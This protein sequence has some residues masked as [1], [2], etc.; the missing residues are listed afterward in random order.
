MQDKYGFNPRKCNSAATFSGCVEREMSKIIIV[1]PTSNEVVNTFENT[2]NG[3][4]SSV[5][6]RLGFDTEVFLPNNCNRGET[7]NS[8]Y[9][10]YNYKV[11]YN[12]S[13]NRNEKYRIISK[14]IKFD[15]NNQYG[16]AMTKPMPTGC[17]HLN[18]D[19]SFKTFNILLE[20]VDLND[21]VGH[22]YLV[23]IE[24]DLEKR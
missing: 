17:I 10:D 3:G 12:L 13:N 8:T 4:F 15:E 23:D 9:K 24:V 20:K 14:I 7:N 2:L 21:Q 18:S 1:L 16:Y 19:T 11:I 5:N 6:T 22:L